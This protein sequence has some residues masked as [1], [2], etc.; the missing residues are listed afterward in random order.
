MLGNRAISQELIDLG[1]R[2]RKRRQ[3]LQWSQEKLAE[4]AGISL[5]TVSRVEGGQSDMSIEVFRK[6][7]GALGTNASEVLGD[8]EPVENGKLHRLLYRIQH[9][10]LDSQKIVIQTVETLVDSLYQ[11]RK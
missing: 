8:A 10:D 11:C 4:I 9:L 3:E 1:E 6:I 7:V 5:N 2:I